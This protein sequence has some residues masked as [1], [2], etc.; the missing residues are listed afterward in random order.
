M[1]P[2]VNFNESSV[3]HDMESM[4]QG[5]EDLNGVLGIKGTAEGTPTPGEEVGVK[6]M[7][8]DTNEWESGN[9]VLQSK[10]TEDEDVLNGPD[11]VA[12]PILGE[13]AMPHHYHLEVEWLADTA[14]P[15][16]THE[17]R[18]PGAAMD[19]TVGPD[20]INHHASVGVTEIEGKIIEKTRKYAYLE[21][22]C[23][24]R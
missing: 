14:G 12:P 20:A 4:K 7:G 1:S 18:R 16:L 5:L 15:P 19:V 10:M 6:Y 11:P 13:P 23:G 3:L 2:N 8:S 17:K 22:L 9:E 24:K 21:A